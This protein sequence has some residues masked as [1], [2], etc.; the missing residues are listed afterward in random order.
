MASKYRARDEVSLSVGVALQFPETY[1]FPGIPE[2]DLP[3]TRIYPTGYAASS[4]GLRDPKVSSPSITPQYTPQHS[5]VSPHVDESLTA[6]AYSRPLR[7]PPTD[8]HTYPFVRSSS[9]Q[10]EASIELLSSPAVIDWD[11][12]FEAA[13][14]IPTPRQHDEQGW[15]RHRRDGR[16]GGGQRGV[17]G[18]RQNLSEP[19][20]LS[21]VKLP[22]AARAEL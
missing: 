9:G 11:S 2:S 19:T 5:N 16:M 3:L 18:R 15:W 1:T 7:D 22:T 12:P 8:A 4:K 14:R 17:V 6:Y 20:I 10:D 13:A 21:P